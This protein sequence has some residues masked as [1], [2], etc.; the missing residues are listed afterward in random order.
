MMTTTT[1]TSTKIEGYRHIF[2]TKGVQTEVDVREV[3]MIVS[4]IRLRE[5][6]EQEKGLDYFQ[7]FEFKDTKMVNKQEEPQ[8]KREFEL[9]YKTTEK[10]LWCVLGE[11]EKFGEYWTIMYPSEY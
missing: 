9:G 11:D 3:M 4:A 7:V 10:K 2:I 8:D 1:Y 6:E 5:E